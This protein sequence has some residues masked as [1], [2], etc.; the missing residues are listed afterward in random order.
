MKTSD[1]LLA[2]AAALA[3][4]A[5]SLYTA[6]GLPSIENIVAQRPAQLETGR[7]VRPFEKP[8]PI[9]L[10][11]TDLYT[12]AWYGGAYEIRDGIIAEINGL[13]SPSS[14]SYPAE[15]IEKSGKMHRDTI[16]KNKDRQWTCYG[17]M[18]LDIFSLEFDKAAASFDK[19]N[20]FR[21]TYREA[22][23]R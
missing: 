6:K 13:V 15:D 21:K 19:G 23:R 9:D 10:L 20:L 16:L 7:Q 12:C 8:E 3:V 17:Q 18:V 1:Y 11:V 5:Y 14:P 22:Q 4:A 2:T